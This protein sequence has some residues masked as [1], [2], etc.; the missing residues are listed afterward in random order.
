[1]KIGILFAMIEEAKSFLAKSPA[2]KTTKLL[3]TEFI[4]TACHGHIIVTAVCGIGKSS[5]AA[6]TQVLITK[7]ECDLVII[8]GSA[9]GMDR[10]V[11]IGDVVIGDTLFYHDLNVPGRGS[12]KIGIDFSA[13][14]KF[15]IKQKV[16]DFITEIIIPENQKDIRKSFD[17]S[18]GAIATGDTSVR[19]PWTNWYIRKKHQP[20]CVEMEGASVAHVCTLN[21]VPFIVIRGI[22]DMAS[23]NALEEF[24]KNIDLASGNAMKV[25]LLILSHISPSVIER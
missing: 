22:S 13:C 23:A 17:V 16:A 8:C 15:Q 20:V 6:C 2:L 3:Q 5:S 21:K 11:K 24:K 14:G 1:M 12:S 25:L 10:S 4:E 9:G 7:Y 18:M 19:H